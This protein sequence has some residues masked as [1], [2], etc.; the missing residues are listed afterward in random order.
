MGGHCP[1][2]T[3]PE[4]CNEVFN[5]MAAQFR[6]AFA[7]ARQLG[8][9]T[10]IGT[11]APLIVPKAVQ[12][13]LKAQGKNPAD[14]AVVR[15]VYE[16]HVPPHH[17]QPSAGLLLDLDA[18][19]LDVGRQQAGAVQGHGRRHQAGHEAMKN[20]QAPFQLATAG[21]VLGP[22]H[23][24]AAFDDDLPKDIPMSAISRNVGQRKWIRAFGRIAGREKWAIPWLESDGRQG[25]AGIQL[26]AGRMRRDAADA[27]AYGCTGLMGL[28]WRTDILAPN[29][30]ALAQAAW[31][32]SWIANRD[33]AKSR[34]LPC[35]DFYADWALANFG[36]EAAPGVAK[37]FT[38]IDGKVP[39]A[40]TGGCPVGSLNPD[41]TPW[42]TVAARFAF[43]DALEKL[44]LFGPQRGQ[45]RTLR[46]L[47]QHV[48]VL[49]V[50][51][52]SALCL[53]RQGG[54]GR[55]HAALGR[56]LPLSVGIGEHAR[57][58]GRGGDHGEPSWLGAAGGAAC[59]PT[60]AEGV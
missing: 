3:T 22:A 31:D 7:F 58:V 5:R 38:A 27:A 37:V 9:K 53:G 39:V 59:Q 60:L 56:H 33:A 19:R 42:A 17:G 48:Q 41:A 44:R 36:P 20:V 13:R 51:G 10:C 45:Y 29:V 34:S 11:E 16:A 52:A 25:L 4:D 2:P 28:Q 57:W 54:A 26:Y 55:N 1:L 30:S 24:R 40:T 15:E 35:D 21:W 8:V 47:A 14:P 6:D 50:V 32:Q 43:V 12:E 18:G 46:L 23:D 49:P